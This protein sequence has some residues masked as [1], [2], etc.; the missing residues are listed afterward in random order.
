MP[1]FTPAEWSKTIAICEDP[2]TM[3][4]SYEIW[5]RA[6]NETAKKSESDSVTVHKVYVDADKLTAYAR[7]NNRPLNSD[8][9]V[10]YAMDVFLGAA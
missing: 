5:L 2:D 4:A 9:R 3:F 7:R 10:I 6:A 8:T 1:W